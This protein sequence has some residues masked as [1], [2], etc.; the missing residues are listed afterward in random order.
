[1]NRR[2]F[3]KLV[4]VTAAGAAL[5]AMPARAAAEAL[6]VVVDTSDGPQALACHQRADCAEAMLY[7]QRYMTV[8]GYRVL[9]SA[10]R[11]LA[12]SASAL[13]VAPGDAIHIYFHRLKE[14]T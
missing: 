5:P 12:A 10:G 13:C 1:M 14:T 7:A 8:T 2:D 11:V 9:N 4:L 6:L 3:F